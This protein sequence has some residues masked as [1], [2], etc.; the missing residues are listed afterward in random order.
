MHTNQK[1][2]GLIIEKQPFPSPNPKVRMYMITYWS[3]ELRVK[4]LLAE[5]K[6]EHIYD[7]FLYL[8]GGIKSVGMVRPARIG[9]FAAEGFIVFAP[10]YR[11]NRGGEGNEDFAGND[12]VDAYAAFDL[13]KQYHRVNSKRIHIFGFSRGGIMALHTAIARKEALSVVTWGGVSD[14]ILTYEERKDLRKM[15]KRVIGGTP[16]KY[17]ERYQD[18]TPLFFIEKL[19]Q[20]IL[21]IHGEKDENVSIQHAKRLEERLTSFGRV[22][23]TWYF[24]NYTHYFPPAMN[25]QIVND[26]CSWMKSKH[27][28]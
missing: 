10:F 9:Q 1:C 16:N 28:A 6:D 8:R 14:M 18:R 22:V 3:D 11:G 4:G 25:R 26:L 24:T 12:R 17:P 2:N 21:I 15:L 27:E 23:E 13:L 19:T 7:G 20:P 5:P